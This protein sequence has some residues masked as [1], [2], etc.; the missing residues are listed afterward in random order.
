MFGPAHRGETLPLV[1][2]G[3]EVGKLYSRPDREPNSQKHMIN[4]FLRDNRPAGTWTVRLYGDQV[5]DGHYDAWIERDSGGANQS[6]FARA[7]SVNSTTT[8]TIANAH[9]MISVGSYDARHPDRPVPF[10]S[11]AGPTADGRLKP[12]L[13]A[14]GA[15]VESTSSPPIDGGATRTSVKSGTSMSSPQV[16]GT[17]ALMLEAAGEPLTI[18]QIRHDLLRSTDKPLANKDRHRYGHGYLNIEK[19]VERSRLRRTTRERASEADG[20]RPTPADLAAT[21]ADPAGAIVETGD[22]DELLSLSELDIRTNGRELRV[23]VRDGRRISIE[24]LAQ[25]L[26]LPR[27]RVFS[28]LLRYDSVLR[29]LWG[30]VGAAPP[31]WQDD[32]RA[33]N[34]YPG[35]REARRVLRQLGTGPLVTSGN[36][37]RTYRPF[38]RWEVTGAVRTPLRFP[39]SAGFRQWLAER[40]TNWQRAAR[41]AELAPKIALLDE[42]ARWLLSRRE[43]AGIYRRWI[44]QDSQQPLKEIALIEMMQMSIN[45][46]LHRDSLRNVDERAER[47]RKMRI[48]KHRVHLL[49]NTATQYMLV[50]RSGLARW[51]R[52]ATALARAMLRRI[53]D[54]AFIDALKDVGRTP[55]YL[56]DDVKQR[57]VESLDSAYRSMI[58]SPIGELVVDRHILP[59]I[60][61]VA[62]EP[63]DYSDFTVQ[64]NPA[65]LRAVQA[66]PQAPRSE[67]AIVILW[68]LFRDQLGNVVGNTPGPDPIW[69]ALVEASGTILLQRIMASAGRQTSAGSTAV[70]TRRMSAWLYR[71]LTTAA[72]MDRGTRVTALAAVGSGDLSPLHRLDW[73]RYRQTGVRLN[74][75]LAILSLAALINTIRTG[76]FRDVK[77][78]ADVIGSLSGFGTAAVQVASSLR[79]TAAVMERGIV[80]TSA[81]ALGVVGGIATIVSSGIEAQR[82]DRRGDIVGRN[83]QITMAVGGGLTVGGFLLGA[84]LASTSTGIGAPL[85]AVLAIVGGIITIGAAIWD[86]VRNW[87]RADSHELFEA[88]VE[89]FGRAG[90][91]FRMIRSQVNPAARQRMRTAY[92]E[93]QLRHNRTRFWD[94]SLSL[95]PYLRD[96]GFTVEHIALLTGKSASQVRRR[97]SR[98]RSSETIALPAAGVPA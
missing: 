29:H 89:H 13:L 22:L 15:R 88:L 40:T 62:A 80:Q 3:E 87:R 64:N 21:P 85:G 42:T 28:I 70:V 81:K 84:A 44:E 10:F 38:W 46:M 90:G 33:G 60:Q 58:S 9:R 83:L 27:S 71:Y 2:D 23:T 92:R 98:R 45:A 96:A 77:T 57:L 69:L 95:A 74:S 78:W 1:I 6:R 79:A 18:D 94:V 54:P 12:D 66:A 14:P 65:F 59:L 8:G 20:D 91:D 37:G 52:E 67:R 26:K 56:P 48:L 73:N 50:E 30:E 68:E 39:M 11:S 49:Q 4:V 41:T 7:D 86:A 24:R 61:A 72:R 51:K 55:G 19:A 93:V 75:V 47:A 25:V 63:Y 43:I 16:A 35:R 17:I 76:D 82:E 31:E 32:P 36:T 97:L 53:E 34:R 5:T